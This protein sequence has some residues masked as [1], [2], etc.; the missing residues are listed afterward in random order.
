M[1]RGGAGGGGTEAGGNEGPSS[2][3]EDGG[4]GSEANGSTWA[5]AAGG[6]APRKPCGGGGGGKNGDRAESGKGEWSS[7]PKPSGG[8]TAASS[9]SGLGDV[10]FMVA[11]KAEGE[12]C[13]TFETGTGAAVEAET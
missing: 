7:D 9:A 2:K 10:L 3:K 13:T 6:E 1:D 8:A 5:I 4:G 11:A 12:P